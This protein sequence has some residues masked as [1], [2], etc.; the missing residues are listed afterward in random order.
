MHE[1]VLFLGFFF[2]SVSRPVASWVDVGH[3]TVAY[4]AERFFTDQC[5]QLVNDLL[6]NSRGFDIS[7]SA[8]WAD[9]VK[10][11]RPY[12]RPWHYIDAEDRP[13]T[14]CSVSYEED[15]GDPGCI[16]TVMENMKEAL[17]Y[18]IHFFGDLHQPLHVE[19]IGRGGND[20]PVCFNN[21]CSRQNLQSVWDTAIPHKINGITH[22]LKHNDERKASAQ[23]AERLYQT[24]A[25]LPSLP[26][27]CSDIRNPLE[28][29]M[30]WATETNSLICNFVLKNGVSWFEDHNLGGEYY[31]QAVPIVEKQI[32]RAAMR[33][34]V[35]INT[36]AAERDSST[37]RLLV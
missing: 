10:R 36:I 9:T 3:R 13:P 33:L 14:T 11:K 24:T 19:A 16:V 12:T 6:T 34:A 29:I 2:F 5:F 37:E 7:D 21:R 31:E 23:W 22:N 26:Q 4:L 35:W 20:I 15:C 32:S 8:V 1:P 17:M 30:E 28:C 18:L 25:K 27:E